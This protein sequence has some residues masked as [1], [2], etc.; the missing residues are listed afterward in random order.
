MVPTRAK[1]GVHPFSVREWTD[2]LLP[3]MIDQLNVSRDVL[4]PL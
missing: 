3:N 4:P 1:K 2:E